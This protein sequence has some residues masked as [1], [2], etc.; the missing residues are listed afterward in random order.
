MVLKEIYL[1]EERKPTKSIK[2][3]LS[4]NRC[5]RA[6]PHTHTLFKVYLPEKKSLSKVL[7][8]FYVYFIKIN[9]KF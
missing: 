1:R 7:S 2:K 8:L 4:N 3:Y 9:T 5:G 6:S